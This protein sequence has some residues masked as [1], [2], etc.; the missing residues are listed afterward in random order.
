MRAGLAE[1]VRSAQ[2]RGIGIFINELI[3]REFYMQVL[4]HCPE[5]LEHEFQ[6]N[7]RHLKWRDHWRPEEKPAAS[8]SI[9]GA[10]AKP[11]SRSW[12]RACAN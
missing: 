9:A 6:E 8:S 2:R 4:W 10:A 1:K 3:W 12:M 11:D 7:Y 5:V